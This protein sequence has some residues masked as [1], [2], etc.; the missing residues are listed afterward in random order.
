MY[1]CMHVCMRVCR[2]FGYICRRV[3]GCGECHGCAIF[4]VCISVMSV[5]MC[6]WC[7]GYVVSV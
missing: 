7:G 6:D 3:N 2:C 1:V 5:W 4:V